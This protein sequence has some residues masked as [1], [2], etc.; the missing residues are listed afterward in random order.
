MVWAGIS[1]QG[2]TDLH[3]IEN[4]KLTAVR[5][6]NVI[7]DVHVR[8]YAGAV[9]PDF[10]LI[11]DNVRAHRAHIRNRYHKEVT[12]VRMDWPAKST[13]LNPI[14]HALDMMQT[15]ISSRHVQPTT[16]QDLRHAIIEE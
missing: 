5:Y 2:K 16:I 1:A 11:D 13:D 4:G 7:L 3:I 15:A 8:T 12:I 6:I 9:G 10:I 14:E